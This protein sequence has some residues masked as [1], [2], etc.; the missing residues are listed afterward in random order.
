MQYR[1]KKWLTEP[2]K[3]NIKLLGGDTFQCELMGDASNAETYMKWYFIYLRIIV[4]R[5]SNCKLLACSK[6]LKRAIKDLKKPSKVPKRES[7]DQKAERELE[8]AACQA[9]SDDAYAK[10]ATAI[11]VHYDLFC[12]LL[13]DKPQV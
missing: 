12:Q 9:K 11:G 8:L 10:H 4:E 2:D 3:I 7:E 6:T 5:K 1:Y 13:S